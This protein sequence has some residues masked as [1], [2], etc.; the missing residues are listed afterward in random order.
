MASWTCTYSVACRPLVYSKCPS[1]MA[2][3]RRS[4]PTTSSCV[5]T[6]CIYFYFSCRQGAALA[7]FLN[8]ST[9]SAVYRVHERV[10]AGCAIRN[11]DA[12]EQA[13]IF[14]L[15]GLGVGVGHWSQ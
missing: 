6:K 10:V 15:G 11:P 13:W 3:V 8:L 9:A 12:V 14:G 4:K 7:F 5:G 2:P 1:R